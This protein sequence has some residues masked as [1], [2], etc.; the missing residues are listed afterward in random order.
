MKRL[1]LALTLFL[2]M[3]AAAQEFVQLSEYRDRHDDHDKISARLFA[4][5]LREHARGHRHHHDL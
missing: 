2:T 3:P 4:Y 5:G 1:F